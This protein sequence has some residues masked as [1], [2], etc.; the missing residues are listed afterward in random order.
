MHLAQST[1]DQTGRAARAHPDILIDREEESPLQAHGVGDMNPDC[2]RHAFT[3]MESGP[4][5]YSSLSVEILE[6]KKPP[7]NSE[8]HM[9][10]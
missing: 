5:S 7:T 1:G 6:Q 8:K 3:I 9:E 10:T 4:Y 2:L